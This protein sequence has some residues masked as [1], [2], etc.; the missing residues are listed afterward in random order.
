MKNWFLILFIIIISGC[1]YFLI[2][3]KMRNN[4]YYK[5][6]NKIW[7]DNNINISIG[8][9]FDTTDIIK[10]FE[11]DSLIFKGKCIKSLDS[12]SADIYLKSKKKELNF[13]VVLNDTIKI[14]KKV[15]R[16]TKKDRLKLLIIK[17]NNKIN[18]KEL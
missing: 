4:F 12:F 11:N 3:S 13:L 10:I 15:L 18:I 2:T 14:E 1:E 5:K 6:Y 17:I 16:N 9:L 8:P 7:E